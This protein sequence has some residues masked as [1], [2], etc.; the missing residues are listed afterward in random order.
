MRSSTGLHP[1]V[2]S[3]RMFN[4]T[5]PLTYMYIHS[6]GRDGRGVMGGVT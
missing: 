5:P 3:D 1:V 6:P 4:C 2:N